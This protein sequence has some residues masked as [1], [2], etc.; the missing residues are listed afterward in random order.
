MPKAALIG[1]HGGSDPGAVNSN[2]G[3]RECDGNLSVTLMVAKLLAFNGI[4]PTLSRDTDVACGGANN[5]NGDINNQIAFGNNSGAD[6]AVAIHFNS[7]PDKS[8]HGCEALYSNSNGLGNDNF[9]LATLLTNN[10]A[11]YTGLTNR[12]VKDVGT[13]IGVCR[14]IKI[15]VAL[16]E[17]AFVSNDSE[18]IWCSDYTYQWILARAITKAICDYFGR[19]Y[20]DMVK[21]TV[22]LNGIKI[23]NGYL[24]DDRNQIPV[25][26]LIA[27]LAEI[28][29]N[30]GVTW[31]D[32]NKIV[33]IIKQ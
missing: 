18:S 6:I 24:I 19:E 23:G 30:L 12:G 32:T 4:E 13:S 20:K 16:V 29:V 17:C 22:Q 27:K 33:N 7:V 3:V 31:D 2:N 5:V 25:G 11:S 21:T 15:P 10:V 28:G 26:L 1:G 8:A 14:A 9:K